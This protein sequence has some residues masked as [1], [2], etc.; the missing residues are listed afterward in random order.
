MTFET[1]WMSGTPIFHNLSNQKYILLILQ[2]LF[3]EANRV[4]RTLVSMC[5]YLDGAGL[6]VAIPDLP[7]MG[8]NPLPASHIS[9]AQILDGTTLLADALTKEGKSLFTVGFRAGC[10]FDS[11]APSKAA[12]R[13]AP[14]PG[15]RLVR[16][17]MR[18]E[19]PEESNDHIVFAQGQKVSRAL[20]AELSVTEM[21][22]LPK[23]R[24]LRL[25]TDKAAADRHV[26]ASPLWRHAE[27]GEDPGLAKLLADDLIDWV[28]T[29]A[30]S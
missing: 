26:N 24:T 5:R 22:P 13:F 28:Q 12:W 2:P 17:M 4:R 29:C 8:E 23:L 30:V 10:L 19:I 14:E 16:T 21:P 1:T 20:L 15:D 7:G 6:G 3:E 25:V 11:I 18:T 9:L 27:P